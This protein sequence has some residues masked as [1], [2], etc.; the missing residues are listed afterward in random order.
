MQKKTQKEKRTPRPSK[1]SLCQN[2]DYI[3]TRDN[4]KSKSNKK[5]IYS[6]EVSND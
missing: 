3:I 1:S 6:T 5:H 2:D 4:E